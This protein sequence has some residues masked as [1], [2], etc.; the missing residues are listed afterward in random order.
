[1]RAGGMGLAL[2]AAL[3]S[4]GCGGS[5]AASDSANLSAKEAEIEATVDLDVLEASGLGMRTVDGSLQ[6]LSVGDDSTDLALADDPDGFDA[7]DIS[8]V[9]DGSDWEAVAGDDDGL[10]VILR[11][12]PPALLVLDADLSTLLVEVALDASAYPDLD[13]DED[14]NVL[15]EGL[16]LMANGHV[17]VA[18]ELDPPALIEFGPADESPSGFATGDAASSFPVPTADTFEA[19]HVWPLSSSAAST[20]PDIS[21]LAV[22]PTGELHLLSDEGRLI[23]LVE[24][25]LGPTEDHAKL[26]RT[27]KLPKKAKHP[28]GLLFLPDETPLVAIDSTS[29]KKNG[30]VLEPLD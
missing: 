12:F 10:V 28:E 6:L 5:D 25:N 4:I 30:F 7:L 1:M 23:A 13:W 22:S 9:A 11:E 14:S 20:A 27:W 26:T 29:K 8:D 2:L 16:V 17:L 21:D 15:A 18:K 3:A 19:L 24:S